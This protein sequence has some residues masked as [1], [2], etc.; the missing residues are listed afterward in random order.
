MTRATDPAARLLARSP[1]PWLAFVLVAALFIWHAS[2][3]AYVVDDAYIS[4]RYA[5]HL[6]TQGELAYNV[7]ERVEGITNL[8]WTLV[9]AATWPLN[10]NLERTAQ[11]GGVA[12]GVLVLFVLWRWGYQRGKLGR[13]MALGPP[14]VLAVSVP[15][16]LWSQSGLETVLVTLLLLGA[17]V[18]A[19]S[20]TFTVGRGLA[21]GLLGGFAFA[22]RPDAG[23]LFVLAVVPRLLRVHVLGV[24]VFWRH[25]PAPSCPARGP[26]KKKGAFLAALALF[27]TVV[28][29]VTLF[30]WLYFG[31]LVPNTFFAKRSFLNLMV[32][33]GLDYVEAILWYFILPSALVLVALGRHIPSGL[34]AVIRHPFVWVSVL[35]GLYLVPTG[36]DWMPYYRYFVPVAPWLLVGL[37]EA[38]ATLRAKRR[39]LFL[40][41]GLTCAAL[42]LAGQGG[43]QRRWLEYNRD[44]LT[45]ELELIAATLG[46]LPEGASIALSV[47]GLIPYRTDRSTVDLLGLNDRVTA[48]SD[49]VP[50]KSLPGHYK[51]NAEHVLSTLRPDYVLL[52]LGAALSKEPRSDVKGWDLEKTLQA[53]PLFCQEYRLTALR[54]PDGRFLNLY[55]RSASVPATR[56]R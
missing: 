7:G 21:C 55:E 17:A 38:V 35:F 15:L 23:L 12:L 29:G 46:P 36:G 27:A 24:H 48:H 47:A 37:W 41:T 30:R 25:D 50:M 43:V 20:R 19:E 5:R 54:A 45:P 52:D 26:T 2:R 6:A 28:G 13:W 1:S 3:F 31:E 11:L 8:L 9:L 42:F 56:E 53:H 40:A 22:T 39:A 32:H 34:L 16:P 4:F 44:K 51:L 33:H 10:E 14:L 18:A 49:P